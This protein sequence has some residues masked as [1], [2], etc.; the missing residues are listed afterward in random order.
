MFTL[1]HIFRWHTFL[2]SVLIWNRFFIHF[3]VIFSR[4]CFFSDNSELLVSVER[5]ESKH[6][7]SFR[8]YIGVIKPILICPVRLVSTRNVI[9]LYNKS[10]LS[11][12]SIS[13]FEEIIVSLSTL[14]GH[15][16]LLETVGMFSMLLSISSFHY[17]L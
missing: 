4:W 16:S 17:V 2:I 7:L 9:T 10:W 6:L 1:A 11:G 5:S 15:C 13:G 14:G 8:E 12:H 3:L